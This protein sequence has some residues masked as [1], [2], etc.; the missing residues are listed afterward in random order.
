[1][2]LLELLREIEILRDVPRSSTAAHGDSGRLGGGDQGSLISS[3]SVGSMGSACGLCSAH[4]RFK[5][6]S[7]TQI[8][9]IVLNW[10]KGA[11]RFPVLTGKFKIYLSE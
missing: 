4:S 7:S 5:L 1:M 6:K 10:G 11:L 9:F 2:E 8:L 3:P